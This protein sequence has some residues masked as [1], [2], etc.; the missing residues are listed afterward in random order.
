MSN[1]NTNVNN[2]AAHNK[3]VIK[4]ENK[5]Q[6]K[7]NYCTFRTI[8]E[9]RDLYNEKIENYQFL[10]DR[11]VHDTA[12]DDVNPM[13]G[14]VGCLGCNHQKP[15]CPMKSGIAYPDHVGVESKLKGL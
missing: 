7:N 15:T 6:S 5:L 14:H 2:M 8:N 9:P 12:R 10:Q 11:Y 1:T 13:N 4:Y 3:N